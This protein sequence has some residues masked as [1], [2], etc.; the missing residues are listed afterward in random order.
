[1]LLTRQP[2]KG[3]NASNGRARLP[4]A[5]GAYTAAYSNLIVTASETMSGSDLRQKLIELTKS[6]DK[7]YGII[8]RKMDYPSSASFDEIRRIAASSQQSGGS[9]RLV[10]IPLLISRVYPDGRE[11]L[12]RGVRFRNLSVRS[13]R[14]II[15]ASK[16]SHAFHFLYNQAPM[17]MIG[18]ARY[19]APV[20]VIAPSLL[21]DDVELER[22][23]EDTPKLPIVP[24]PAA[25]EKTAPAA[26][27]Q[28]R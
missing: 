11:E 27:T 17:A 24:S 1:V 7:P 3:F 28:R 20:S 6:M 14:D 4:G 18:G 25:M 5:Y 12:I 9:A 15:A 8:V 19:V 23:Q 16:E 13:L 26:P 10:S 21:F 22:P 2:V